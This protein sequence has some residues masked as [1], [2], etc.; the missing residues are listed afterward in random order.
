[1]TME[2]KLCELHELQD[3][4][5]KAAQ[6]WSEHKKSHSNRLGLPGITPEGKCIG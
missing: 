3:I 1:M 5:D 6:V 2:K 4:R